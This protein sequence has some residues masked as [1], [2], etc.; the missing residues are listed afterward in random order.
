MIRDST[1]SC[2][3][4]ELDG[5]AAD[6]RRNVAEVISEWDNYL[7][8]CNDGDDTAEFVMFVFSDSV[9]RGRGKALAEFIRERKLG[10]L[11]QSPVRKNP[12]SGNKIQT[13]LWC[14]DYRHLRERV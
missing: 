6:P 7:E 5:L 10:S 14:P 12:H 4:G 8:Y 2:G 1:V 13:W 9:D 3:V 11:R